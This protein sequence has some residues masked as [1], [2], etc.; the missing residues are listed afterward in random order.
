MRELVDGSGNLLSRYA[1]DPYGVV[2]TAHTAANSSTPPIDTTF[3][4]TG[5]YVHAT[6]GLNLT[7]FRAYDPNTGRWLSR[8]SLKNAEMSQ[9]PDLY[10]YVLNGPINEIDPEGLQAVPLPYVPPVVPPAWVYDAGLLI[11]NGVVI[12]V[13]I[14]I[15]CTKKNCPPCNPPVGTIG[16]RVDT[17][18]P[19]EPHWPYPGTHVHLYVMQQNP[20][21][22]QCFWADAKKPLKKVIGPNDPLPPGA[23]PLP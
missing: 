2:T 9:G 1:Y 10:A 4:F 12:T 13:A 5:D 17:V 22:C 3:Q 14:V 6:S 7:K 8:D 11:V 21:N 19:S 20:N 18:P 23:V 15:L 16:Y